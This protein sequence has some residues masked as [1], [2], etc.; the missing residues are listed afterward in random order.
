VSTPAGLKF[1]NFQNKE[2]GPL[3]VIFDVEGTLVDCVR[4]MLE[5]LR[6]IVESAADIAKPLSR[7]ELSPKG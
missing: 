3:A 7:I 4:H 6:L 5:S 2:P 1:D